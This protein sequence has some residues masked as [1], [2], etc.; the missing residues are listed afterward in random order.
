MYECYCAVCVSI[1]AYLSLNYL[2]YILRSLLF[3][4]RF[5]VLLS[6]LFCYFLHVLL[7][8]LC[9]MI[10]TASPCILITVLFFCVK[11]QARC[12]RVVT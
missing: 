9:F 2:F 11:V 8:I 3:S 10:C 6:V 5:K 12:H 4:F 7:S 1:F